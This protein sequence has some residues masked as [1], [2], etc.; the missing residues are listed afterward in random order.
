MSKKIEFF[1]Q[2]YRG[3]KTI[4]SMN[5]FVVLAGSIFMQM[6]LVGAGIPQGAPGST[7]ISATGRGGVYSPHRLFAHLQ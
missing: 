4:C 1:A 2:A 3:R 7:T 5:F 6:R